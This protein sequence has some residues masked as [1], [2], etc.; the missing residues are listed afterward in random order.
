LADVEG[1]EVEFHAIPLLSQ[2]VTI[3]MVT[4]WESNGIAWKKD[5][6]R[7]NARL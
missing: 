7:N 2:D 4:S 3:L 5:Y 6:A 1:K